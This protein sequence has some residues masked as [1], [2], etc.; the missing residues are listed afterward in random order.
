MLTQGVEPRHERV[1][2]PILGSENNYVPFLFS[3]R[4]A[5]ASSEAP[6]HRQRD[7]GEAR[8]QFAPFIPDGDSEPLFK[9]TY[10][11]PQPPVVCGL[12][13]TVA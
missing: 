2:E 10:T 12:Q 13:R 5:A 3:S 1:G 7:V 11:P 9:V 8:E 4:Y 6:T